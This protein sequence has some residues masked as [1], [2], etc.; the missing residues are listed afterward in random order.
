VNEEFVK[1]STSYNIKKGGLGGW[2]HISIET[3]RRCGLLGAVSVKQKFQDPLFAKRVVTKTLLTKSR[4]SSADK[5]LIV[6]KTLATKAANN[7]FGFTGRSHTQETKM[8]MSKTRHERG[9]N[10]KE[11][12]SQF[13]S[14]WIT[15]GIEN[16]KINKLDKIPLGWKKGRTFSK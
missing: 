4:K 15:D 10:A 2:D 8:Q 9:L 12:H 6:E 3:R 13:G 1:S 16:S 5:K 14:M 11:K 7:D